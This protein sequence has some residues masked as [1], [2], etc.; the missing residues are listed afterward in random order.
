MGL[1]WTNLLGGRGLVGRVVA[2]EDEV[3]GKARDDALER[4]PVVDA[5][6]A[7][8]AVS[9]FCHVR[10]PGHVEHGPRNR[11]P[12]DVSREQ[13]HGHTT[14]LQKRLLGENKTPQF[15]Q[16]RVRPRLSKFCVLFSAAFT[17]Q[18][19]T[20]REGTLTYTIM[21]KLSTSTTHACK[22]GRRIQTAA[23]IQT[24]I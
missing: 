15:A 7:L 19:G 23:Q 3:H 21:Q 1:D 2:V 24:P 22:E 20:W 6:E 18:F 10:F 4:G 8:G 16:E 14:K 17:L 5:E 13:K 9:F 11:T 12:T